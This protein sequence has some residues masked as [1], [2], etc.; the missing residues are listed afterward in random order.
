MLTTNENEKTDLIT[1]ININWW[2]KIQ[3]K[4]NC[5]QFNMTLTASYHKT[6]FETIANSNSL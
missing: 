4:C 2:L 3:M 5:G 6:D 1:L